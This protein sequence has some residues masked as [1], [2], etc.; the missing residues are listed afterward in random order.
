VPKPKYDD[1]TDSEYQALLL[2]KLVPI[3][4][5]SY[6]GNS[7]VSYRF[8]EVDASLALTSVCQRCELVE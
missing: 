1:V 2:R 5:S 6:V 3:G 8:A 7:K 4:D